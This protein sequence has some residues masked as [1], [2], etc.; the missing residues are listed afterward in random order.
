MCF[1]GLNAPKRH[2]DKSTCGKGDNLIYAKI[3]HN[4]LQYLD[5]VLTS[6]NQKEEGGKLTPGTCNILATCGKE[7]THYIQYSICDV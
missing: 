7:K 6:E 4:R 1:Q 3:T 2:T 5:C